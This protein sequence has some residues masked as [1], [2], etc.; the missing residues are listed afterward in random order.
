MMN[1]KKKKKGKDSLQRGF[2]NLLALR[3]SLKSM[4]NKISTVSTPSLRIV[5]LL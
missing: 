1:E 3:W 5:P 2:G 4:W